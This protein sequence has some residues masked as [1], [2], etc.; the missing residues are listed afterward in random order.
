M[1]KELAQKAVEDNALSHRATL[2]A[3]AVI[4]PPAVVSTWYF[5]DPLDAPL[6]VFYFKYRSIAALQEELVIPRS[7]EPSPQPLDLGA[8][9]IRE[10]GRVTQSELL[11]SNERGKTSSEGSVK[12]EPSEDQMSQR[13]RKVVKM[14][15]GREAVDLTEDD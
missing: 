5:V 2:S 7:R 9:P 15:D 13:P 14:S 10:V 6:A 3:A 4:D 8:L 1:Q 12:R 11:R